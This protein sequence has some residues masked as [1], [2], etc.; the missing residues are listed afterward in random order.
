ME[1]SASDLNEVRTQAGLVTLARRMADSIEVC[2]RSYYF[3]TYESCFVGK[4]AVSWMIKAAV[5]DSVEAALDLGNQMLKAGLPACD[6]GVVLVA[7]SLTWL[8]GCFNNSLKHE[9]SCVLGVKRERREF[10]SAPFGEPDS[11]TNFRVFG[12]SAF[13]QG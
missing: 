9:L 3:V 8:V 1:R 2:A 10:I 12:L 5:V 11:L 4:D 13:R 7:V 6:G